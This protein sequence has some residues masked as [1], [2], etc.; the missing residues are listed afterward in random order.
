LKHVDVSVLIVGGA[1]CGLASAIFLSELGVD[2]W[3]VERHPATS[4]A[5]KAH[6]LNPRTMEL[7]RE[8]GL[9]DEIYARGAPL[10]NMSRV[11]FYTPLGGNGPLDRKTLGVVDAFGGGSLRERYAKLTPCRATNYPQ[12]RLEPFMHEKA[13]RH[14]RAKLNYNHELISFIQDT[15]GVTATVKDRADESTYTVRAKYMIAADGGRKVGPALSIQMVGIPRLVDMMSAH[16]RAD[17]SPYIDDD[18]PMI[19][20]FNNPDLSGGTW[21]SGVVVAMG[22]ENWDRHSEEWLMHFGFQPDDPAQFDTNGLKGKIRDLLKLPNLEIDI[23]KTNNWQVQGVLAERFREGRIFLA[24]DA[25]HRHP[26]TTGLGLNSA[27]QDAHNLCWKLAAVLKGHAGEKLLDSYEAERRAVTGRNVDWAL[28]SFQNHFVIDAAIGLI[29]G[30][31][32]ELNQ[33]AFQLLFSDTFI[34]RARRQRFEEALALHRIEFQAIHMEIGFAYDSGAIV[35]DGS[36]APEFKPFGEDF[37]TVARPGHRVPHTWLDNDGEVISSLDLIG[38]ENFVLLAGRE[39]DTWITAATDAA[40][41]LGV[42]LRT[43]KI[44]DKIVD[45]EG[46]WEELCEITHSGALLVRPDG[47]VGWRAKSASQFAENNL[48]EVLSTLTGR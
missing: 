47:H 22:P 21:G 8:V 45:I 25:A 48:V 36:D 39:G 40:K 43:Y 26:P 15:G 23:L 29:P 24:G 2:V 28:L 18:T 13:R 44:G 38:G 17:L 33:M 20:W 12:L 32:P 6:Y 19:R 30:A 31:P 3:L 37:R 35:P 46:A 41:H 34:G 1:G 11:G 14:S 16:F 42:P 4:P 10:E 7:F 5:P 9:A 27:I